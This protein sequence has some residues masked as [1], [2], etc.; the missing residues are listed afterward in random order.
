MEETNMSG[1]SGQSPER[2]AIIGLL[3]KLELDLVASIVQQRFRSARKDLIKRYHSF[4]FGDPVLQAIA[5]EEVAKIIANLR[6]AVEKSPVVRDDEL[7]V[8]L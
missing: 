4:Y 2:Q 1:D 6:E 8:V 7:P 3:A 5:Q